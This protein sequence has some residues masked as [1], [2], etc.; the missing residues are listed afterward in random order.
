[1][2]EGEAWPAVCFLMFHVKPEHEFFLAYMDSV[3][4]LA[5]GAGGRLLVGKAW[6]CHMFPTI[7]LTLKWILKWMID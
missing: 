4:L 3:C 6:H 1:V 5:A 7:H 2:L